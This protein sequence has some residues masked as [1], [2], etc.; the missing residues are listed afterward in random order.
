LPALSTLNPNAG[1]VEYNCAFFNHAM[2]SDG[3]STSAMQGALSSG[4]EG[5]GD[6]GGG[7]VGAVGSI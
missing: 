7:D 1:N 6:A 2:G 5:V 3:G 4:G